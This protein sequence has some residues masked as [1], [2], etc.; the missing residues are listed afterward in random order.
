MVVPPIFVRRTGDPESP[1]AGEKTHLSGCEHPSLLVFSPADALLARR[2]CLSSTFPIPAIA[3]TLLCA[4]PSLRLCVK[5]SGRNLRLSALSAVTPYARIWVYLCDLWA[6]GWLCD[7]L[8]S[9]CLGGCDGFRRNLCAFSV[10]LWFSGK[11]VTIFV[12]RRTVPRRRAHRPGP[13]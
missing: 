13:R 3:P 10:S 2:F 8:V 1:V 5:R 12:G 7:V 4:S 11:L 6:D 9:L